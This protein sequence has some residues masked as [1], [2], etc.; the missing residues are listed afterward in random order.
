MAA[1]DSTASTTAWLSNGTSRLAKP[2]RENTSTPDA[3]GT[4]SV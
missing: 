4:A 2:I 3:D 1:G